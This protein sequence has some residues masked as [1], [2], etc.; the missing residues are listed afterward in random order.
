MWQTSDRFFRVYVLARNV[1][2]QKI[3]FAM[4]RA[5]LSIPQ[6]VFVLWDAGTVLRRSPPTDLA[7]AGSKQNKY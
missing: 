1:G 3:D 6:V 2:T 5:G 4:G 7:I